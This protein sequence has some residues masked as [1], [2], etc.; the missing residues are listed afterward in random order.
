MNW[1]SEQVSKRF[2]E[3]AQCFIKEYSD[4]IDPTVNMHVSNGKSN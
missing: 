4:Y 2:T 1:W 3:K